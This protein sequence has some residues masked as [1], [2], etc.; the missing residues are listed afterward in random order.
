MNCS[1]Y[2]F[3]SIERASA[4]LTLLLGH[5][6]G[7]GKKRKRAFAIAASLSGPGEKGYYASATKRY[8]QKF[9]PEMFV[10]NI[11]A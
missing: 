7:E 3:R 6:S 5:I 4:G 10:R 11:D 9:L 1:P 2:V 8:P